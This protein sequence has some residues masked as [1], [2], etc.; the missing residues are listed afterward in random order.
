[1][2][3]PR[4]LAS[5]SRE[6]YIPGHAGKGVKWSDVHLKM[7]A[8]E[9]CLP[10]SRPARRICGIHA[11]AAIAHAVD[12]GWVKPGEVSVPEDAWGSEGYDKG[13]MEEFLAGQARAT[14][15]SSDAS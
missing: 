3:D 6:M 7:L 9:D 11:T 10:T 12:E 5:A 13:L 4:L 2:L 8:F 15:A 1:M 14:H